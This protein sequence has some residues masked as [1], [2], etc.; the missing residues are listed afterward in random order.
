MRTF[1]S[2]KS[3]KEVFF[4]MLIIVNYKMPKMVKEVCV[5]FK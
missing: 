5:L 2:P 4:E 1:V 3:L